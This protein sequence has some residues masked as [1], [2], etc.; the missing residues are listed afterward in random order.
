MLKFMEY[1]D[2]FKNK[3]VMQAEQIGKILF[4]NSAN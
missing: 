1:C 3:V 4:V 2:L